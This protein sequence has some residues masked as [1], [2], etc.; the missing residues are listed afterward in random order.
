MI[1]TAAKLFD[2]L[3]V[4]VAENSDKHCAFSLEDRMAML[5]KSIPTVLAD[6]YRI[7]V[8]SVGK[9]YL[10]AHALELG[11]TH[12]VR[13]VRNQADFAYEHVM[14]NVNSDIAPTLVTV[15]LTP[16]RGLIDISSSVVKGLT[17]PKGWERV[18]S[19]MVPLPVMNHLDNWKNKV[20]RG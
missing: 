14:R 17:G 15:F 10:A 4:A 9:T 13:G 19:P 8:G 18:V 2:K 6:L 1:E 3:H 12:L 7:T 16:P 5:V 20:E 11:A